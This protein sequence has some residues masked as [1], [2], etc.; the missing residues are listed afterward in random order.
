MMD[1]VSSEREKALCARV[2]YKLA[3]S[4]AV[5]NMTFLKGSS[6]M[7]YMCDHVVSVYS[8]CVWSHVVHVQ[9][10]EIFSGV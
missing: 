3:G 1:G 6:I 8:Q 7:C 2:L 4:L 9:S 5:Q 10:Y